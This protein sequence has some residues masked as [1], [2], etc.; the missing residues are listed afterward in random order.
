MAFG[1]TGVGFRNPS[2]I[3]ANTVIVEGPKGGLY[4]YNGTP[5]L[6]NPPILSITQNAVDPYGNTITP[7]LSLSGLPELIYSGPP[8]FDNLIAAISGS[9]GT[10]E[11]GNTYVQGL[12]VGQQGGNQ[13]QLL[14]ASGNPITVTT[15]ISGIL[16]G[17]ANLTTTDDSESIG[18]ILG[19]AILN[20]GA[21][22][23]LTTLLSSPIGGGILNSNP[24]FTNGIAGWTGENNATVA[25]SSLNPF[26]NSQGSMLMTPNGVTSGPEAGTAINY[27]A[28]NPNVTYSYTAQVFSPQGWSTGGNG[29][30]IGINWYTATGTYISSSFTGYTAVPANTYT[31]L[32]Q[33]VTSPATAAYAQ[34]FLSASNV[35]PAT[36]LFY[37]GYAGISGPASE[38]M[39]LLLSTENDG[40]TDTS[41]AMLGTIT[42]PD[43]TTLVF[44]PVIWIAPYALVLY[45]GASGVTVVTKTS[46][47]G[48]IAIPAGVTTAKAECWGGG[49]GGHAGIVYPTTANGGEYGGGGGEYAQEPALAV[50]PSG[51]VS[52]SVGAGS[53]GTAPGGG[54]PSNA[55]NSTL[56]GS[57]AT[58]TSHGATVTG[59]LPIGGTGSTDTVHYNGGNGGTNPH[60]NTFPA[61]IYNGGAG[62]GSSAGTSA[63]GNNGSNTTSNT[64]ANGATAPTGGGN[65]GKGGGT[66]SSGTN[67]ANAS[68][69]GGGGGGGWGNASSATSGGN[70]ANGQ[71]R[72]TYSTGG[73]GVLASFASA[74][75]TDPFGTAIQANG[76]VP[77]LVAVEPGVAGTPEVW[78]YVGAASQPAFGSGWS[79]TNASNEALAFKLLA[80]QNLVLIKGLVANGTA[81]N[82]APLFTLPAAYQPGTQQQFVCI[83]NPGAAAVLKTV[84]VQ[85]NG[86]VLVAAG[87]AGVGNYTVQCLVSLDINAG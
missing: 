56:T 45:S 58:V 76:M 7:S 68:S 21:A 74:A 61:G 57:A 29:C 25:A 42:T 51:T 20:S 36:T 81:A 16:A 85:A 28:V 12:Q 3:I 47:S 23:K 82:S 67:G 75:V 27:V 52:Y 30:Q 8:A 26:G 6:G 32:T 4:V 65:G 40:G 86:Q 71:V 14:P 13:I 2:E 38:G 73:P 50:T 55:G 60:A 69:P 24:T 53:A 49:G 1:D 59:N 15:A 41:W 66:G 83:E 72:L 35:P 87:A 78:H 5:S 17:I 63:A 62:G 80:E 79:N 18:G 31:Q 33:S 22:S 39:A 43:D 77:P 37:W 11:F 64:G 44:N 34:L 84:A 9:S 46:G 54:T 10:D 70:G 19:A 48:T